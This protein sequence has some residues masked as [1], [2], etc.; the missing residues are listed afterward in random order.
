M[1]AEMVETCTNQRKA[2]TALLNALVEC[3]EW[4]TFSP[5]DDIVRVGEYVKGLLLVKRGKGEVC[6]DQF[7]ERIMRRQDRFA[8]EI[9]KKVESQNLV[10]AKA[11][12]DVSAFP[13]DNFQETLKTQCFY[14]TNSTN[15]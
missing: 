7:V 1:S 14:R 12:C 8:E 10:R 13:S 15:S 2:N 4:S 11:F 5:G 9:R 3:V 6:H